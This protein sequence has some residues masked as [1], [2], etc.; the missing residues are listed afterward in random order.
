MHARNFE[1]AQPGNNNGRIRRLVTDNADSRGTRRR[2][3]GCIGHQDFQ[4]RTRL[5][6]EY[7]ATV[8]HRKLYGRLVSGEAHCAAT[9]HIDLAASRNSNPRGSLVPHGD[10]ITIEKRGAERERTLTHRC[11]LAIHGLSDNVRFREGW[12]G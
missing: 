7:H 5:A 10:S 6:A 9:E 11:G 2:T 3:D 8:F 4:R 12:E 1:R